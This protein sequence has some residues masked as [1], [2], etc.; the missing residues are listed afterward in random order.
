MGG[1]IMYTLE[2]IMETWKE[3]YGEDMAEE[4]KGFLNTLQGQGD[5]IMKSRRLLIP[6]IQKEV[7]YDLWLNDKLFTEEQDEVIEN[8]IQKQIQGEK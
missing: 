1:K 6:E 4:Y 3:V 8:E 7:L 2:Q 5:S